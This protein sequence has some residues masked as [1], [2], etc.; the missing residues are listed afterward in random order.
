MLYGVC[1]IPVSKR[2][3]ATIADYSTGVPP[4]GLANAIRVTD[5]TIHFLPSLLSA[6]R[7]PTEWQLVT[8]SA[9]CDDGATVSMTMPTAVPVDGADATQTKVFRTKSDTLS[10]AASVGAS[11]ADVRA[12]V[13]SVKAEQASITSDV[14]VLSA[15]LHSLPDCADLGSVSDAAHARVSLDIV[16]GS[17]QVEPPGS[18]RLVNELAATVQCGA[19]ATTSDGGSAT[20][21]A[22]PRAGPESI[23]LLVVKLHSIACEMGPVSHAVSTLSTSAFEHVLTI[24]QPALPDQSAD[25]TDL[26]TAAAARASWTDARAASLRPF[27]SVI[28][29]CNNL[30]SDVCDLCDLVELWK[31]K[32]IPSLLLYCD[33][34][35]YATL[36]LYSGMLLLSRCDDRQLLSVCVCQCL[37]YCYIWA[38]RACPHATWR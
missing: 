18:I 23:M 17:S 7:A 4:T 11:V 35:H 26:A 27:S 24:P 32:A 16:V 28:A 14:G 8:V 37:R 1:P 30:H 33:A 38:R 12:S 15:R 20:A 10:C 3:Q 34:R 31:A 6:C 13:R 22:V 5:T 2:C 25:T 36:M 9:D 19:S 21:T 29:R